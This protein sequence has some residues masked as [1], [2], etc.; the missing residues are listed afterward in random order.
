MPR[1]TAPRRGSLAFYPRKRAK[2]V[3]PRFRRWPLVEDTVPLG[4]YGY[5]AGMTHL[6][7]TDARKRTPTSGR[8]VF[9]SVTIIE[10]PPLF[11]YG[12]R[13]YTLDHLG[14][15]RVLTEVWAEKLPRYLKRRIT[16]PDKVEHSLE[17]AP[18]EGVVDVRLLISTQPWLI[19]LKK[20]PDVAEIALGGKTVEDKLS[21]AGEKLGKEIRVS[22]VFQEGEWIDVKSVTKG[23]G[24]QGVVK[25]FGVFD[26]S[27]KKEKTKRAVGSIGPWHPPKVVWTVPRAGQMGFHSRTEFNK[28]VFLIGNGEEKPITPAGGFL[29]YG[30]VKSDYIVLKGSVPGPAKRI[31]GM[32][33]AIRPP[34]K[35]FSVGGITYVSLSSKQGA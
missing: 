9:S 27:H 5:K 11:V 19:K 13:F 15:K 33:K 23:K 26:F 32:R 17:N 25:R 24:F 34:K 16:L 20:T 28:Y 30:E 3:V 14:R 6:L 2:R 8:E 1:R 7:Y 4:F 18:K 35:A 29:N 10:T 31:I 12:V 22:E 21:Y